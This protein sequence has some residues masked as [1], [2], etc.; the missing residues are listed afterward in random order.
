MEKAT[1]ECYNRSEHRHLT[2]KQMLSFTSILSAKRFQLF[3]CVHMQEIFFLLLQCGRQNW[4][5]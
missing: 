5:A 2:A 3:I 4:T 1:P